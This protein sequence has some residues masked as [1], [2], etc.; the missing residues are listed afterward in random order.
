MPYRL[1]VKIFRMVTR[2]GWGRIPGFLLLAGMAALY[3]GLPYAALDGDVATFGL[4]GEDLV[5]F[6]QWPTVLYGQNYLVSP[7]PYL[8]AF[9]RT[10]WPAVS[11]AL[12][13]AL[14]G[15]MLS[16]GGLALV[17]EGFRGVQRRRGE[18]V[19]WPACFLAILV[20]G[21][22]PFIVDHAKNSGVEIS[23]FLLG[24]TLF[25]GTRLEGGSPDSSAHARRARIGW[26]VLLGVVSGVA[27]ISR[28][29][30]AFYSLPLAGLLLLRAYRQ[31]GFKSA[32]LAVAGLAVG[33][34]AGYSPMLAHQFFRAADWPFPYRLAFQLGTWPEIKESVRVTFGD[35][36]PTVFG[37]R[38]EMS[39]QPLR[40]ALWAL[41]VLPGYGWAVW[42]RPDRVSVL[43]H[44]LV[45]GSLA[46]LAA[47][48]LVPALSLDG[49]QRRY[50]LPVF[51][52]GVWL[53]CRFMP[54][55]G[56]RNVLTGALC[57]LLAGLSVPRWTA[58]LERS[59]I[60]DRQ[61]R[62]ARA[63]LVPELAAYDS[64]ILANYWE[65]ALLVF[66]AEG[67]LRIEAYPWGCVRT[68]GWVRKADFDRRT[69]WL[70]P[71][72]QG[73]DTAERLRAAEGPDIMS[74]VV[75]TALKNRFL[76]RSCEVWEFPGR[77]MA[78]RLMLQHQPLYFRTPYPPGSGPLRDRDAEP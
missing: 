29:P 47:L 40:F 57:L 18:G 11:P 4:M 41:L 13:L 74:G 71:L 28:P 24:V 36:L 25:I 78:S 60:R 68:Y 1:G 76:G 12:A 51:V 53:C 39:F 20:A 52:T 33:V 55:P 31:S 44:A 73:R 16:L 17:L 72:G 64:A 15:A 5:R 10:V 45:A 6:G 63:R 32:G 34:L 77:P 67:R 65:A 42:R 26:W 48:S 30:S 62:E 61:M 23:L 59:V 43:D 19:I 75:R 38:P 56:W 70:I 66:L 22:V 35:I 46:V 21:N 2:I 14:A 8:F 69:L 27:V 58:R 9:W 50:C 49:E 54:A 3:L 37:V 7:T